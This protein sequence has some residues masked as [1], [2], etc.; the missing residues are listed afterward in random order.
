MA[1]LTIPAKNKIF[2]EPE[3]IAS[4]LE[5]IGIFFEQWSGLDEL[6]E[7]ATDQ[8]I[9]DFYKKEIE[10][11]CE[12]GRY[13]VAD[14]INVNPQTPGLEE[15]LAKFNREHWHSEDEVRFIVKGRG[16]FHIAPENGDVA[17]IEMAPGDLITVPA[18]TRH[19]F[20]LCEEKTIRAIRLFQD[21]SGWTPY[22]TNSGIDGD[23]QPLCFGPANFP[24]Q[25]RQ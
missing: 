24:A 9:L 18:G 4:E 21:P 20:N 2:R 15:M 6:G 5:K 22:Y 12:R 11:L 8:Q 1:I 25:A 13:V 19:W 7:N 10:I 3:I 16:I 14:V 17:A 23:Y